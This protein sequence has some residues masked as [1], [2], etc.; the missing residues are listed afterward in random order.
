MNPAVPDNPGEW[1]WKR[2]WIAFAICILSAEG[3]IA[4]LSR[5]CMP[6]FDLSILVGQL[7]MMNVLAS[8]IILGIVGI[9]AFAVASFPRS[10]D[11]RPKWPRL[12]FLAIAL[13]GL[14]LAT[15]VRF[16]PRTIA[17]VIG[18]LGCGVLVGVLVRQI[19]WFRRSWLLIGIVIAVTLGSF[20]WAFGHYG[21]NNCWP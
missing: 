12:I 8:P 15:V 16:D 1:Q 17:S 10:I 5:S 20:A 9:P 2:G 18:V 21:Q 6:S 7:L 11:L 19:E 14:L 4:G 3:S 13:S